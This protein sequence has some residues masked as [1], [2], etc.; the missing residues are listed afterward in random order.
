MNVSDDRLPPEIDG[1]ADEQL[2]SV[3]LSVVSDLKKIQLYRPPLGLRDKV[4]KR[5]RSSHH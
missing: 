1:S 4:M 2:S 5:V 3:A